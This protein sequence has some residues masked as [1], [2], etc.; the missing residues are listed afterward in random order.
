MSKDVFFDS[1]SVTFELLMEQIEE[2]ICKN[3]FYP[4]NG[5]LLPPN[6]ISTYTFITNEGCDSTVIIH[7]LEVPQLAASF[8]GED[9]V[10][11]KY[12]VV[13]ESPYENTIWNDGFMGS[14]FTATEEGVFYA[15]GTDDLGCSYID[16][17]T[18]AFDIPFEE[19]SVEI[20]KD[21]FYFFQGDFLPVN[22]STLYNIY[23]ASGCDSAFLI[24]VSEILPQEISFLGE[25]FISCKDEVILQSPFEL[26][27]WND[28]AT[29]PELQIDQEG[30]FHAEAEDSLGCVFI[31]SISVRFETPVKEISVA[32]CKNEFYSF[33]GDLLSPSSSYDYILEGNNDCDTTLTIYVNETISQSIFEISSISICEDEYVLQSPYDSTIWNNEIVS[34][35]FKVT[36]EGFY[37]AEALDQ[38]NCVLKDTIYVEFANPSIYLPNVISKRSEYN[39]CFR[40]IFSDKKDYS[41]TITIY[42]RWGNMIFSKTGSETKW[43]G[44][45]NDNLVESGVYAYVL[46]MGSSCTGK[47]SQYGTLTVL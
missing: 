16:S 8:L 18:V 28:G 41:Y 7:V 27:T 37:T 22:T 24:H 9:V 13:L 23:N 43:C 42:D 10:S 35:E 3:D 21:D 31:D 47:I 12:P 32:V 39:N 20:C 5:D 26:T 30:T 11:C 19:L 1:I 14:Q 33:N 44:L 38:N 4:F 40:P 6:S 46:E 34:T 2:A 36:K 29:G 25:D 45:H 15:I 17:I